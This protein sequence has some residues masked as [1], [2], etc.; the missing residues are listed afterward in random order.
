HLN[1]EEDLRGD[2]YDAR[3]RPRPRRNHLHPR[4]QSSLRFVF[5]LHSRFPL[6]YLRCFSPLLVKQMPRV[7]SSALTTSAGAMKKNMKLVCQTRVE[8]PTNSPIHANSR[9]KRGTVRVAERP[10]PRHAV[11]TS[12]R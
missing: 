8:T 3:E 5:Y 7:R 11:P 9:H 4:T 1:I 6:S 12:Q 10:T 2:K